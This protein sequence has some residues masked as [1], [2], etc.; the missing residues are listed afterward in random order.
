MNI[1]DNPQDLKKL[2]K[3]DVAGSIAKFPDQIEQAWGE[4][5]KITFPDEYK[6]IE[7][8]V[9]AGMGGSALGP[10]LI[11][12]IYKNELKI[13]LTI[14]RDYKLP[15]F[16]GPNTLVVL[17]SYSG[18][19]EEVLSSAEDAVSHRAKIIGIAEGGKLG[20]FI[21]ENNLPAYLFDPKNN[22]SG[23]PRMG[24]GYAVAGLLGLF[25]SLDLFKIEETE[26]LDSIASLRALNLSF[27][28]EKASPENF[29]K[30]IATK[31]QGSSVA[32]VGAE[33]LS[34]NAHIFANQLNET[35]KT[36]SSYHQISELNHHL[37]EGLARP[38]GLGK[39]LKFLILESDQYS[40]KIK[41]RVAI[42]KDVIE[43]QKV[44]TISIKFE[45]GSHL[46]Q[47]LDG[48][49]I[50]SYITFYLG[51]LNGFDPADIPWVDYFKEQLA[52]D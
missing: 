10:E 27:S 30:E 51:I 38:E 20:D 7:N 18:S 37:L 49:L 23:Q 26:I 15:F 52:K 48:I 32:V 21:K 22:P 46:N 33:F 25:K 31:L 39:S 29:T 8:I 47:A 12:D 50:S 42:T 28:P 5:T 17:S 2:D 4:S 6:K 41:R 43:K 34:A 3:S 35:A 36:F 40:E 13:P 16:T 11:R 14:S 19:T 9:V 44:E 45:E 24:L 1:L